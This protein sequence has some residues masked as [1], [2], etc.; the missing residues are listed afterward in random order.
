M[1]TLQQKVTKDR[2]YLAMVNTDSIQLHSE[3]GPQK[4]NS[5]DQLDNIKNKQT[6]TT[7]HRQKT[8]V[9]TVSR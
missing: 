7:P 6:N 4:T 5:Y 3:S 1:D 2:L 8:T 9:K